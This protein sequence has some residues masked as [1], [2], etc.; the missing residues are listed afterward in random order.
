MCHEFETSMIL[1][2][3]L[4]SSMHKFAL[5]KS[6]LNMFKCVAM[7]RGHILSG[8]GISHMTSMQENISLGG[9]EGL[10]GFSLKALKYP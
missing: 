10:W 1:E 2:Q 8:R 9:D 4:R 6:K 5:Q 3:E 7:F